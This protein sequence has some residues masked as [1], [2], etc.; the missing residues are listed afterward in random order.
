MCWGNISPQKTLTVLQR[1]ETVLSSLSYSNMNLVARNES[2]FVNLQ[3]VWHLLFKLCQQTSS[4]LLTGSLDKQCIKCSAAYIANSLFVMFGE[5]LY[6]IFADFICSDPHLNSKKNNAVNSLSYIHT[7]WIFENCFET[8][9]LTLKLFILNFWWTDCRCSS[10]P[11]SKVWLTDSGS[12]TV[13]YCCAEGVI[14]VQ[15]R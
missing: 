13:W 11:E 15:G 1:Q 4:E 2:N 7:G 10:C 12:A 6:A 5:C 14:N 9:A 3:A 8:A